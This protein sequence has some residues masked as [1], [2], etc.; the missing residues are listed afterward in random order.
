MNQ[1]LSS[2]QSI[3]I[4]M[5]S[6]ALIL[7]I[8]V[9]VF[10]Y[11][12]NKNKPQTVIETKMDDGFKTK[13]YCNLVFEFCVDYPAGLIANPP[14]ANG[15]GLEFHDSKGFLFVASGI[16]NASDDTVKTEM[17]SQME[18]LDKITYQATGRDWFVLSGRKGSDVLYLK[19]YV[20]KGSINHIYIKHPDT[21]QANSEYAKYISVIS[22][23]FKPGDIGEF[24]S[25]SIDGD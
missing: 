15:D 4:G 13:K 11:L 12:D 14:P 19:S 7:S 9:A 5:L 2:K 3:L 16:N 25:F 24:K 1:N 17:E 8:G 6:G 18:S 20:G 22:E 21:P 23:S 10:L